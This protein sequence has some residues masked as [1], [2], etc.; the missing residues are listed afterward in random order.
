MSINVWSLIQKKK[1]ICGEGRYI[2]FLDMLN[3]LL[4]LSPK[5]PVLCD[6]SM[7]VYCVHLTG[8]S[9]HEN[10]TQLWGRSGRC[11][12]YESPH[13]VFCTSDSICMYIKLHWNTSTATWYWLSS[14]YSQ[15]Q[16]FISIN[17][18]WFWESPSLSIYVS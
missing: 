5:T 16:Y 7:G 14:P 15:K 6:I 13:C 17:F 18:S 12:L 1:K 2:H 4:W 10:I 3:Y 8:F 9:F 11:F